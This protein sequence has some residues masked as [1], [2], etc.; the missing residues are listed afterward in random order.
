MSISKNFE[1]AIQV[2]KTSEGNFTANISDNWRE[3]PMVD[4]RCLY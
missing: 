1:D 3:L 4:T 2:N